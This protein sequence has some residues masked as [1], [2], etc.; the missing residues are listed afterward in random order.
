MRQI[1]STKLIYT[2]IA[3]IRILHGFVLL[4]LTSQI[5]IPLNPIPITLQ[6]VGVML[7]GF[8]FNRSEA[9]TAVSTYLIFGTLGM[10]IF[11]DFSGGIAK[12]MGPTSGYLIGFLASVAIMT[13]IRE[14]F[15]EDNLFIHFLNGLIGTSVTFIF[16]IFWLTRFVGIDQAIQLGFMPFIFTGIL[17]ILLTAFSVR[18]IKFGKIIK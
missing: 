4:F 5:S 17:K 10:P 15:P 11:A 1:L 3:L 9:I 14:Y 6:T 12:L 18:Y 7:I 2:D 16:G 13:T 8:T